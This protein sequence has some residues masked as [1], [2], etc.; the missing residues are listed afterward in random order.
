MIQLTRR[1]IDDIATLSSRL[2]KRHTYNNIRDP[3][4]QLVGI[5]PDFFNITSS[6]S[7]NNKAQSV[8]FLDLLILPNCFRTALE[9]TLYDKREHP[10]LSTLSTR[11][12]TF[13]Q[14]TSLLSANCKY[15]CIIS[16]V[17]RY[18][19]RITIYGE[20][21]ERCVALISRLTE[22]NGYDLQKCLHVLRCKLMR[23]RPFSHRP[24]LTPFIIFKRI[25][26]LC[27]KRQ[28]GAHT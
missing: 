20:F 2:F 4:I 9:T 25:S 10:P 21:V 11:F 27:L 13:P 28:R 8:A 15:N 6:H 17:H 1:Y 16:Q 18:A 3:Y 24:G 14:I 7:D 23:L 26:D 5:Y 12:I 19:S 22:T